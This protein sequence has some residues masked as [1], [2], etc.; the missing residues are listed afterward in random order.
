[1]SS[2]RP[3]GTCGSR[4]GRET[5]YRDPLVT[6]GMGGGAGPEWR[7]GAPFCESWIMMIIL[8]LFF[9]F[10]CVLLGVCE[11]GSWRDIWHYSQVFIGFRPSMINN[12]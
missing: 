10:V 7:W 12:L 1:M 6:F 5:Q 8:A 11:G 2:L 3:A 4:E 9:Y